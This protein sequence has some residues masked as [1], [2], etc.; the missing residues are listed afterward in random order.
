MTRK[1]YKMIAEAIKKH[2]DESKTAKGEFAELVD[3]LSFAFILDNPN[4]VSEIFAK[5]CGL[6]TE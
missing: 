1:D 5:A 2:R 3:T 6:D 4:F